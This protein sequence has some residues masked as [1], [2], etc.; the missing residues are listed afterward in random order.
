MARKKTSSAIV[1]FEGGQVPAL[2]E[3][4]VDRFA[5]YA[6][7]HAATAKAA[8]G[9]PT[10]STRGGK[11]KYQGEELGDRL[12]VVILDAIYLNEF[13]EGE[14]D[15]QNLS[16]PT[17]F[18]L[19]YDEDDLAPPD[20]LEGRQVKEGEG[21]ADCDWNVFGS[22]DGGRGKGC[23]NER[24]LVLLPSD[25]INDLETLATQEGARLRV[26]VTSVSKVPKGVEGFSWSTYVN[27]LTSG[28][29]PLFAVVTE[30]ILTPNTD[31]GGFTMSF[32]PVG[33]IQ[34]PE[35][36]EAIEG[37]LKEAV[38]YLEAPP[39]LDEGGGE[40][41]A[42]GPKKTARRKVSRRAAAEGRGGSKKTTSRRRP[43]K[44]DD[45]D[46][47]AAQAPA[48]RKSGGRARSKF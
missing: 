22:G 46:G 12:E 6:K 4:M 39:M 30:I 2:P 18:A 40:K 41:K 42:G 32:A 43:K 13:Y 33:A 10:I 21:C 9:W 38:T 44:D 45:G 20:D 8:G 19:G 15:P 27:R 26:P 16:S 35:V 1:P 17:C 5:G 7:K 48:A 25:A 47:Q 36:L 11:F 24:R 14:F 28:G 31:R 3:D 29:L 37:R 23:K 34:D